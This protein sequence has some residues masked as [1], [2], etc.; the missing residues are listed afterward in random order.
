MILKL[1]LMINRDLFVRFMEILK[2][3]KFDVYEHPEG[4]HIIIHIKQRLKK[5]INKFINVLFMYEDIE[6]LKRY[7]FCS[8]DLRNDLKVE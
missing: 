6:E 1:N 8:Y 7:K 4:E 3:V 2:G 5:S